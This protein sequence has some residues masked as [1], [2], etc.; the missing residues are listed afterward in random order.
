MAELM[1][2]NPQTPFTLEIVLPVYNEEKILRQTVLTIIQYLNDHPLPVYWW[3]RIVDN[4]ST[5]GTQKIG[6]ELSQTLSRSVQY[7]RLEQKGRGRAL[8]TAWGDSDADILCYMDIDLSTELEYLS[9][10]IQ[11]ILDGDASL[12]IG[13]R[14]SKESTIQRSLRRE[15]ISR[16]YNLMLK[17]FLRAKCDDAQC[18]FKAID[19]TLGRELMIQVKD[20]EWFFD[21]E[22]LILAQRQGLKIAQIPIKWVEDS[23]SRVSII[24][25]AIKDLQGIVR[26]FKLR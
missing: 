4:G 23:D 8:K 19:G 1:E 15:F 3:I 10:L 9:T 24:S 17:I 11:P 21:T 16:S 14:L 20:N 5:D 7:L 13:N 6:Q 26:L 2:M 12:S 25:T 18:G 22:L